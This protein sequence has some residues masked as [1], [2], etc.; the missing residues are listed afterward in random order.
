MS[1]IAEVGQNDTRKQYREKIMWR[2]GGGG[3][4][5]HDPCNNQRLIAPE[6]VNQNKN[7]TSL[8]IAD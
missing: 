8:Y 4:A 5:C 7:K 3:D 6:R 1:H 2:G